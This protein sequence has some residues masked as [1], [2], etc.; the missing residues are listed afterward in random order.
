MRA[1]RLRETLEKL[2]ATC[3]KSSRPN[4][5]LVTHGVFMKA[6]TN[7]SGIDLPRLGWAAYRI[8]KGDDGN[9]VLVTAD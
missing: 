5:A 4:V 2:V 7:D 1:M 8:Q 6:L 3:E 9:V